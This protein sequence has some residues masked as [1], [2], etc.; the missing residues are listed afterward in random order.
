[1]F[2]SDEERASTQARRLLAQAEAE[3]LEKRFSKQLKITP[4]KKTAYKLANNY[5]SGKALTKKTGGLK[6]APV[7][8]IK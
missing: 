7:Y 6:L 2:N 1:M 4:R 5:C 8:S 3:V